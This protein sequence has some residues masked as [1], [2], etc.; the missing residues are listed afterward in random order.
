MSAPALDCV[1]DASVGA[2]LFLLEPLSPNAHKLFEGLAASP[3]RRLFVPDLFY[4]ECANVLLKHVRRGGYSVR[5]ARRDLADLRSLALTAVPT[6]KLVD[7][8]LS[9]AEAE[10]I[11]AYDGCYVALADEL[12]VPLITADMKLV[13]R[14]AGTAHQVR[15]LD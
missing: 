10:G 15:A 1:V 2:M 14:L 12:E 3:P 11:T 6:Y 7:G 5:E 8:A 13:R 4:V 9:I